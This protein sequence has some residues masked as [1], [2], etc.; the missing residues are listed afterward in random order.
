MQTYLQNY[1]DYDAQRLQ[2]GQLA[3]IHLPPPPML[4]RHFLSAQDVLTASHAGSGTS[5][6]SHNGG[7]IV[8]VKKLIVH[9]DHP[10]CKRKN[11]GSSLDEED[12]RMPLLETVAKELDDATATLEEAVKRSKE[13]T[14]KQDT[15][16]DRITETVK[17][18]DAVESLIGGEVFQQVRYRSCSLYNYQLAWEG[19]C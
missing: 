12:K 4:C 2:K 11:S 9:S 10:G 15:A 1:F 19:I 5:S 14:T 18:A 3:S 17:M 6:T 13:I 16:K 8:D 7:P